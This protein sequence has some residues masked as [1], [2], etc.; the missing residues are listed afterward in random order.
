MLICFRVKAVNIIKVALPSTSPSIPTSSTTLACTISSDGWIRTFDLAPILSST[1]DNAIEL[2]A[3]AEY[4][5]KG[6][7]LTC[8]TVAD[9]ELVDENRAKNSKRKR[10][11]EDEVVEEDDEGAWVGSD[12]DASPKEDD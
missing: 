6:S 10:A 3:I 12:D 5:T 9:G 2:Q 1:T 7:R 8:L 4:D 11:D